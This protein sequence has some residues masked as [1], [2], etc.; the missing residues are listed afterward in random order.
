MKTNKFAAL[1]IASIV[2]VASLSFAAT[3]QAAD[4]PVAINSPSFSIAD[5]GTYNYVPGEWSGD[6]TSLT[7]AWYSCPSA[8]LGAIGDATELT[9][10]L[11]DAGCTFVSSEHTLAAD[12]FDNVSTFPVVIE[13]ANETSAAFMGNNFV[14]YDKSLG[15]IAYSAAPQAAVVA[16]RTLH[17]SGNSAYL[18]AESRSALKALLA[19]VTKTSKV[20]IT[21]DAY[22]AKGGSA[23]KNHA[24][25][26]GRARQVMFFFKGHAIT[27]TFKINLH[28]SKLTG[29]AG[30]KATVKLAIGSGSS[31]E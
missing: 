22:A 10:Q 5:D 1:V 20:T 4:A 25:A 29:V 8:Q 3:A 18:N 28:I 15:P 27:A 31:P 19:K 11:T 30:R 24:I 17:F 23:A 21:I 16:T 12:T 2:S 26:R 6:V 7:M 14:M 9:T 13:I